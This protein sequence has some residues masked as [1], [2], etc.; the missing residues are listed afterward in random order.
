VATVGCRIHFDCTAFDQYHDPTRALG[1]PWWGLSDESL[2][3]GGEARN[4]YTLT[5]TATA[6][7]TLIASADIDGVRSNEVRIRIER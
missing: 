3:N 5:V 6:A 7:G 1:S 4:Q 2:I